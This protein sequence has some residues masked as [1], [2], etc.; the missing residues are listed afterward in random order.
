MIRGLDIYTHKKVF[1]QMRLNGMRQNFSWE[2]SAIQYL[3][4]Y[5]RALTSSK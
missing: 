5:A 4:L 1:K 2:K 3:D